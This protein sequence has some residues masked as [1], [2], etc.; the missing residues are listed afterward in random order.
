MLIPMFQSQPTGPNARSANCARIAAI[1]VIALGAGVLFGWALDSAI[2]KS[3]VPGLESMKANTAVCLTLCGFSLW[4]AESRSNPGV[5]AARLAAVLVIVIGAI[6]LV[7]HESGWNLGIDELIVRDPN[8]A[9]HFG[10]RMALLSSIAFLLFGT[11][12]WLIQSGRSI[13]LAQTLSVI[14]VLGSMAI[15]LGYCYHAPI[16]F[17][18]SM[19]PAMALHTALAFLILGAGV[20]SSRWESGIM[21]VF[22]NQTASAVMARRLVPAA[23][24]APP[25]VG[26]L[27]LWGQRQG[28][29]G[30]ESGVALFAVLNAAVL[31][32]AL[33]RRAQSVYQLDNERQSVSDKLRISQE[34]HQFQA[35]AMPQIVWTANPAGELTH[36]NGRWWDYSGQSL[37]ESLGEGWVKAV[38]PDDVN[39]STESW[40][41]AL[42]SGQRFEMEYRLRRASDQTFRWHLARAIPLRDSNGEIVEWIGTCTDID[43]QK[44][45]GEAL[46][47]GHD[48]LG[49]RVR[50]RTSQLAEANELLKAEVAERKRVESK[51]RETSTLQRAILDSANYSIISTDSRGLIRT[52]NARAVHSLGYTRSDVVGKR[53]ALFFH[54]PEEIANRAR[55]LSK[56]LEQSIEPGFEVL[57]AKARMGLVDENEWSYVRNDGSRF[58]AL[59]SVTAIRDVDGAVSGYLTVGRDITDR[60]RIEAELKKTKEA[61]ESANH[62]KSEFLANI[63]HEIRTP[64]NGIIGMT[65]LVLD[66]ELSPMVRE[67]LLLVRTSAD[68]LLSLVNRILDFSKIEAGK[69]DLECTEFSVRSCLEDAHLFLAPL[70]AAKGLSLTW[71]IDRELPERLTG[72]PARLRQ[73]VLNLIDNAIKFTGKGKVEM[74]VA[75]FRREA[76]SVMLEFSISDTGIGIAPE[77]QRRIFEPFAQADGSTTRHYGGSG[78]GLTISSKIIEQMGGL[79]SVESEVGRGSTFRFTA[80]F[81][82]PASDNATV[83]ATLAREKPIAGIASSGDPIRI[84]V[85]EDNL[86]NQKV[87]RAILEKWGHRLVLVHNGAQAVAAHAREHFDLILMDIQMPEMDG[88]E[89]TAAIRKKE[90]GSGVRTPVVAMTAHAMKGDKDRCLAGGMDEY[91]SKPFDT[92]DL[93]RIV[94]TL[95]YGASQNKPVLARTVVDRAVLLEE[96]GDDQELLESIVEIFLESTPELLVKLREAVAAE[97]A[98]L[99]EKTAHCLKDSV[100]QFGAARALELTQQL[101]SAGNRK[102]MTQAGSILRAL[103]REM[104]QVRNAIRSMA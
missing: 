80:R 48:E 92:R 88:L 8:G 14:A 71:Q 103:D 34:R 66:L 44:K 31:L 72:D 22:S 104:E 49:D 52:F 3:V 11:A 65:D 10:G 29:Y 45:I 99:L 17:L 90:A 24:L 89:A 51:L 84:L 32:V 21:T 67:Y 37:E 91:I 16:L 41:E 101:E 63:S 93:H 95:G 86:V 1:V 20:I 57:A 81:G 33:W 87:I 46:R 97:D 35:E 19:R 7:E 55:Q 77:N 30:T 98:E 2:L 62:A 60:R 9:P 96:L 54:D 12:L 38:H 79:V 69:L 40:K 85:A 39:V 28:F 23:L 18:P 70:A 61:A 83:K 42:K 25:L 47:K 56:E 27:C 73:I 26:A 102:A 78:L 15:L 4:L 100:A 68:A 5:A 13:A 75:V 64:M 36:T 74:Q 94:T 50:E 82:L 43:D 58:P 6:T 53:G 59:L 76:K